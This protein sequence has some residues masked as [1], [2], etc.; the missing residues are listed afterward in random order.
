MKDIESLLYKIFG[1]FFKEKKTP[2]YL[3]G[4][5]KEL[6]DERCNDTNAQATRKSK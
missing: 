6:T 2:Q 3:T 5:R 1:R 4:K